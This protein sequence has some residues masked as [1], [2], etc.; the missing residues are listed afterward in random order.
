MIEYKTFCKGDFEGSEWSFVSDYQ[1]VRAVRETL[2]EP[3][4]HDSYFVRIVEGSYVEVWGMYGTV[5]TFGKMAF[6]CL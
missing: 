1:D 3:S 2:P 6:K 5:P 4:D